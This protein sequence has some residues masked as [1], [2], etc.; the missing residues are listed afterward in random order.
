MPLRKESTWWK[1]ETQIAMVG[2]Q[3]VEDSHLAQP[4]WQLR[5]GL[6]KVWEAMGEFGLY[7]SP[8]PCHTQRETW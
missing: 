6:Q 1:W 8:T 7:A 3:H 5:Q 2:S 4:Q